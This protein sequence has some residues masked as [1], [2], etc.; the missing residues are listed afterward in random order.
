M[1]HVIFAVAYY[2]SH[3]ET[4]DIMRTFF[5][6]TVDDIVDGAFVVLLEYVG[7]EYVLAYEFLVCHR[8]DDVTSV[9]EEDDNIVE[10]GAVGY[11]FVFFQA[12]TDET[13]FAVDV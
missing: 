2:G 6:V 12:G 4:L 11:E 3:G 9:A 7:I 5:S 8:S 1:C 13:L 10:V